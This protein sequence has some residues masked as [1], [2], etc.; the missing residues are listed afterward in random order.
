MILEDICMFAIVNR[1]QFENHSLKELLGVFIFVIVLNVTFF[2][3]FE[4]GL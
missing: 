3:C 1:L 4:H 2:V